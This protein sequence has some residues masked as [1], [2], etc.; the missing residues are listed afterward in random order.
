LQNRLPVNL[1]A[2]QQGLREARL[3]GRFEL[4]S[5]HPAVI[6]DVAHNPQAV[7]SL[8]RNLDEME[9]SGR[10]LAVVGMLADKDIAG[11]LAALAGKIDVWLVTGLDVP[12]GAPASSLE[13]VVSGLGGQIESFASPEQAFER[14]VG[15]AGENDRIAAFGSFYTVAAVMRALANRA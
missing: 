6:L 12:R 4:V 2:M 15:L 10:T 11:A 9:C 7:A 8:A 14:A 3:A 5:E 1:A 13:K